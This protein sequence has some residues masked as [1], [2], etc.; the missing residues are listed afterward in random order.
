M[1]AEEE[2]FGERIQMYLRESGYSQKNLADKVC[3]HPKVLSRKLNKSGNAHLTQLEVKLIIKTL[4]GWHAITTI[5]EMVH[6][7][8]LV[9][10]KPA[11]F[12]SEEWQQSPLNELQVEPVQPLQTI[13]AA[14]LIA[15]PALPHHNVPAPITRLI[16]RSWAVER[17]LFLLKREDVRLVTL[18]GPGGCGKTRLAQGVAGKLVESFSD[19]VW[20]VSLAGLSEASLVPMSIIQ[21]LGITPSPSLPTSQSL[22]AYLRDKDMLLVLDNFEHILAASSLVDELLAAASGLKILVTSREVLHLYGEREF[23]VQPLE[24]PNPS[25]ALDSAE[26]EQYSSIQL[27]TERVQA[28]VP[29]FTLSPEN[30]SSVMQICAKLDGL[31]LALELAAAQVK[32]F[33][34]AQLLQK[35]E[36]SRFSFLT[37]NARNLPDRHRTLHNT[38]EWSYQLLSPAE[39][40]C[41]IQLAIFSGGWSLE[42]AAALFKEFGKQETAGAKEPTDTSSLLDRLYQLLDKSLVVQQTSSEGDTS[43]FM[44]LETLREYAL[45]KLMQQGLL[46]QL[47]DWHACYYLGFAESAELGL[48]GKQQLIWLERLAEEQ[49]NIRAALE[50]SLRRAQAD[51]VSAP[52]RASTIEGNERKDACGAHLAG[53]VCLRLTSALNPYWIWK[54]YIA[55]GRTWLSYGLALPMKDDAGETLLAAR[56]KALSEAAILAHLRND[57]AAAVDLAEA[58]V[59][60]WRQLDDPDG[61]AYALFN[62][63]WLAHVQGNLE[64]AHT[65]FDQSLS[66][67]IPDRNPWLRAQLYYSLG[68]MELFAGEVEQGRAYLTESQ[69]LFEQVGDMRGRADVLNAQYGFYIFEGKFSEAIKGLLQGIATSMALGHKKFVAEAI[70]IIGFAV[71]LRG[72]P[73]R[74]QAI[75]MAAHLMGA[76]EMLFESVGVTTWLTTQP[77]VAQTIQWMS[78]QAGEQV[79]QDAWNAGRQLSLEEAIALAYQNA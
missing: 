27:F 32:L 75:L 13:E 68:Q 29:D 47:R 8:R 25:L 49:D 16:G 28:V 43:R 22:T 79:W 69:L 37:G 24:I 9:H 76:A 34:P 59:R 3:L 78:S 5:D 18:F 4:V 14:S 6:L 67:L 42:A 12:T 21:V 51:G 53:E 77:K 60:M 65:V 15:L 71:G 30:A 66:L 63:G 36:T 31:P 57:K 54:G 56:A 23:N 39:Q 19:G 20:F 70:G 38:L 17:L 61:L 72:E 45:G 10:M 73:E 44:M 58:S 7:L 48:C 35:L 52:L 11:I 33:P 74:G 46:E 40:L 64:F 2:N 1:L 55:E 41:F 62:Q 50:W 26:L